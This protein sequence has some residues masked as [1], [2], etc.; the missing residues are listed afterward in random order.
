MIRL[1]QHTLWLDEEQKPDAELDSLDEN[2][3]WDS[4]S[5]RRYHAITGPR[6]SQLSAGSRKIYDYEMDNDDF[7][8]GSDDLG[9]GDDFIDI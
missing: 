7:E 4:P 2:V 3:F 8:E 5:R 1:S 9:S 6:V